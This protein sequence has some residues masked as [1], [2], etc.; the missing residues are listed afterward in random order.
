MAKQVFLLSPN[1]HNVDSAKL[2]SVCKALSIQFDISDENV[3]VDKNMIDYMYENNGY[4]LN[5]RMLSLILKNMLPE[6]EEMIF[7]PGQYTHILASCLSLLKNY[8]DENFEQYVAGI[9]I[10]INEHN[11]ESQETILKILNS[12]VLSE[13]TKQQ[14]ILKTDFQLENI[15]TC[16]DIQLWD[17]LMQHV[18]ISPTWNNIYTYYSCPINEDAET[19]GITEALVTY[20]NAKECSEQLSQKHIFDDADSGEIVRMMKDIFSSGKLNDESFPILLRAVSFQFTNFEFSATLESQS[21]ML[22]ESNKVIFEAITLSSLMQYHPTLAANWVA[23]NWTAFINIFGEVKLNSRSW[24]KLI[25]RT[26]GNS[27]Q[28]NFLLEKIPGE[29]VVAVLDLGAS[30]PNEIISKKRVK[31]DY[32][33]I[34]RI[35][36]NPAIEKNIVNVLLTENL[37]N[38]NEKEAR[39][40]LLNMGAE[41]AELT[42]RANPK[43]PKSDLME[44]L[45]MA[46]KD[47]GFFVASF[48]TK[49]KY[50]HVTSTPKEDPE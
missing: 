3:N 11:Q 1:D 50:I 31:A 22:V 46:L 25:E 43:V 7:Q 40:I 8:I 49:N 33:T 24:A 16:N 41:Y 23:D 28:Q 6:Y 21:K 9:F 15:D 37:G 26:A 38:L 2:V 17:L 30:I 47:N 39:Q 44:N 19:A 10:T 13:N 34:E 29:N 35:S 27:A 12:E 18:R 48:E 32:R 20:L 4:V 36:L 45:L 5:Q 14:V 42:Q